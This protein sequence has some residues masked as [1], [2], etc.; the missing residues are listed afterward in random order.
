MNNKILQTI[1][2][3]PVFW[4]A[5]IV[6]F[7]LWLLYLIFS[8]GIFK[9]LALALSLLSKIWLV[10]YLVINNIMHGIHKLAGRTLIS[11]D[12]AVTDFFGGVYNFVYMIKSTIESFCVNK[13]PIYDINGNQ[14]LDKNGTPKYNYVSRRPFAGYAL[15]ISLLLVLWISLPTWLHTEDKNNFFNVA[16]STYIVTEKEVL[17]MIFLE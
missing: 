15:I 9:L 3:I 6:L 16:Y 12:Q 5:L 1:L 8:R 4:R 14:V 17:E 11:A 10:P 7:M 2:D 13:I